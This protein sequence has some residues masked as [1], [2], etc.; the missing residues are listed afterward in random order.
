MV[1]LPWVISI[2]EEAAGKSA[3]GGCMADTVSTGAENQESEKM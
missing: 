2:S 3:A 1:V